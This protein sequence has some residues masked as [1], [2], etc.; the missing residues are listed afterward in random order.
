[1]VS[2]LQARLL[3]ATSV[4]AVAAVIAV[5]LAARQ[6]TRHEFLKFREELQ[7]LAPDV[8]RSDP[9]VV[10]SL[11]D[12]VCCGAESLR[13][14]AEAL[15]PHELVIV[16]GGD[17][18]REL[19]AAAGQPSQTLRDIR[20]SIQNGTL[21]FEAARP[22]A[23]TDERVTLQFKM[24]ATPLRMG[25]GRPAV[26]YLLTLPP[27]DGRPGDAFLVSV[28]LRLLYATAIVGA[29]AVL[30]TWLVTRQAVRPLRD[31]ESATA[32]LAGGDLGARVAED[33]ADEI[34]RLAR[35]FNAMA[36]RLERQQELRRNLVH[37]VSHELRAPVTALRCR[38][39]SIVDGVSPDPRV[40]L[41]G[42]REDVVQLGQLVDDLQE[43]ALAEAGEL[44]L[45][46][47]EAP[48]APL[49]ASAVR[50]AGLER[51]PRLR[52]DCPADL[53]ASMD[54]VRTRQALVN[55]L[56][57]ADRHTPAGDEI[58]VRA[59]EAARDVAIEVHN[60]GS[61]LDDDQIG[62]VF[63]RFYRAD[64]SRQ[65]ATGGTGLG[66]AI[67]KHLVEAQRGRVWARREEDGMTFGIAL[68]AAGS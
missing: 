33:G 9:L 53:V 36:A 8:D 66:L 20:V 65:R 52:I 38:L 25:D 3:L 68:P 10:A 24:P 43:I 42:A 61:T 15:K 22:Q 67:V 4:L 39:E 64:P 56:T 40:A 21:T 63:D 60:T 27:A 31:L 57:N 54:T 58:A 13:A 12:G 29:L 32:A 41:E 49:L 17:D 30:A 26:L 28:D 37:D 1:M 46:I 18:D 5:A 7:S 19:I 62:Q 44:R 2:S 6:G 50:G 34:A 45:S 47:S 16:L 23:A 55:L 11:L 35:G 51:D 59:S 14:A 48:V